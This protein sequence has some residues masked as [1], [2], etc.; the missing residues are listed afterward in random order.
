MQKVKTH[1]YLNAIVLL[2]SASTMAKMKRQ[3]KAA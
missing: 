3:D 2:A 1:V